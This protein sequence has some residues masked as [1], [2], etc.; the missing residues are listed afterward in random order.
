MSLVRTHSMSIYEHPGIMKQDGVN[1]ET[2]ERLVFSFL[3]SNSELVGKIDK[4]LAD[5]ND[6]M[7]KLYEHMSA[8]ESISVAR[9]GAYIREVKNHIFGYGQLQ[10]L[11]EDDEVTD[12][13]GTRFNHFIVK[14]GGKRQKI[15]N[16]F[17]SEAEFNRFCKLIV[18]RNGGVL[19][20]NRTHARVS[21][22]RYGLRINVT[23][24]PRSRET[25]LTIR[26]HRLV[27][28]SLDELAG[29]GMLDG[30]SLSILEKASKDMRS[31]LMIGRG[32]AGKTT[33]LRAVLKKI[34][35]LRRIMVC[36]SESEIFPENPNFL[37]LRTLG[38]EYGEKV[39]L[40]D[41]IRDGLTMSLDGYCI[42][43]LVGAEAFDFIRAGNT[44][45]AIYGTLHAN[46]P[47]EAIPRLLALV[48]TDEFNDTRKLDRDVISA[49]DIVVYLSDFKV[50]QIARVSE[51]GIEVLYDKRL[52][53]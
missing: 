37:S 9:E 51:N 45:H 15:S 47:D 31:M 24:P 46:S 3:E 34:D 25:H 2:L 35:G 11:I 14:K 33:L 19:N 48:D 18:A 10:R 1:E 41:L 7:Y 17:K 12:I 23:I 6:L 28:Y 49:L 8:S 42:G 43:E 36:E 13:D 50:I 53:S 44:D 5:E 40:S 52:D 32:A 27:A 38:S 20:E 4:G 22:E 29:L 26:K 21:D 30:E 39:S 16:E